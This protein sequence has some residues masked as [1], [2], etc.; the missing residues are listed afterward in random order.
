MTRKEF[1]YRL[2]EQLLPLPADERVSAL[3]Y[4]DEYFDDAGP[5]NEQKILEELG[6][7]RTVAESI[8]RE[9][10]Q[11]N[12]GWR[13]DASSGQRTAPPPYTAP[14]YPSAPRPAVEKSNTWIWVLVAVFTCWIWGP[15]LLALLG[16][17]LGLLIAVVSV[18]GGLVGAA[19]AVLAAGVLIFGCSVGILAAAPGAGVLGLG[20]GLVLT[21]AGILSLILMIWLAYKVVPTVF[22]WAVNICRMPFHRRRGGQQ[23]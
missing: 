1:M 21:G 6:D 14:P 4:Y 9:Y 3:K 13:P 23:A 18:L 20:T 11:N 7:P 17:V 8:I 15:V 19:G 10:A 16:V 12:P 22:R 2:A 5:E